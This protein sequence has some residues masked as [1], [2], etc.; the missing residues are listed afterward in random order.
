MNPLDDFELQG[1][2]REEALHRLVD[3]VLRAYAQTRFLLVMN[4]LRFG[5][6]SDD[7]QELQGL[8]GTRH[9]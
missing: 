9:S 3:G 5:L 7:A 2:E 8:P 1:P 4:I 6:V